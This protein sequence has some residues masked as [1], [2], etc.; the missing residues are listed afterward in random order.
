[1]R[2]LGF[3]ILFTIK[4]V[5]PASAM[6][7]GAQEIPAAHTQPE[8]MFVG[9]SGNFCTGVAIARDLVLTAA[10]CVHA[11]D[12]YKLVELDFNDK[13][14]LKDTVAVARHP[15]FNL[16]TM[17]AHRA[18]ADVAL[19]KLK[20]PLS[21][22]PAPLLPSR[23]RIS[24]GERFV[25]HGYGAAVRGDGKSAGRLRK[26]ALV[27]TGQ[28]GNLQLRLVD[29]ATGGTRPGLGACTGDSGAPAFQETPS[30]LAVIGVVSWSTGPNG[31][32]GCGGFTGVTPLELY[33]DWIR[34]QASKM[35]S[36]LRD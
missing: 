24:A 34:E 18:T 10:H 32:D 30:G 6:V 4:M 3:V 36:P 19:M 21:V 12:S 31:E 23:P 15:Q 7:G 13:P 35:G 9:S 20:L 2:I 8:V 14:I 33:R 28:P 16:K 27:A 11:G 1:M 5:C 17:L 29:P 22:R 26:A 25:V